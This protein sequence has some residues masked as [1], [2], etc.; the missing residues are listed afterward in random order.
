MQE[1]I[2]QNITRLKKWLISNIITP[3]YSSARDNVIISHGPYNYTTF[4]TQVFKRTDILTHLL[5]KYQTY[6]L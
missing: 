3:V 5:S 4:L 2:I 6:A 1:R